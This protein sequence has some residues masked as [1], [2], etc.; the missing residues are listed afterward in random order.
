MQDGFNLRNKVLVHLLAYK[1][2][3]SEANVPQVVK[4]LVNILGTDYFI[5]SCWFNY[6]EHDQNVSASY[7]YVIILL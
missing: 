6:F 7:G 2:N 5:W 1:D 4:D 3:E